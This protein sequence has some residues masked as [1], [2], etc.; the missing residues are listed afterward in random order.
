M[1]TFTAALLVIG[2]PAA[3]IGYFV[4][5]DGPFVGGIMAIFLAGMLMGGWTLLPY[6]LGFYTP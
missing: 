4:E 1:A 6:L 5:D 2:I 3:V